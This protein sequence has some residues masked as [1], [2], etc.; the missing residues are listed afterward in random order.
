MDR[1]TGL[2]VGLLEREGRHTAV[3]RL[4]LNALLMTILVPL[5]AAGEV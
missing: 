2:E 4:S 1:L 3:V 5:L